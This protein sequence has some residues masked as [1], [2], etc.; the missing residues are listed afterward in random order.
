MKKYA[1]LFV[2][3]FFGAWISTAVAQTFNVTFQ[4]DMSVQIAKTTFDPTKDVIQ[5]RGDF[6]NWGTTDMTPISADSKIYRA[7]IACAAGTAKYKY[8]FKHGTGV[9]AD[10]WESDQA[11]DSHNRE[12]A[13]TAVATVPVVFFNNEVMP[14]GAS[15]D[16]TFKIDMRIPFKQKKLDSV[17]GKVFV[18]GDFNGWNTTANQLTGPAADSTYTALIPINSAQLIHYKFLFNDKSGG[19]PWEDNFA[20]GSGN[21]ETWI[22]DGAQAITKFWNDTDPSVTLKDGAIN[23]TVDM[24]PMSMMNMFNPAIDT[25]KIRGAFN[26][27]GDNDRSKS[28]MFQDPIS[29]NQF[30]NSIAFVGE[31]VGQ[32]ELYKFK[33]QLRTEK[34][35]LVG[36]AQYERPFS[37]GGGNRSVIFAGS[38]SQNTDPAVYYFNDIDPKYIVPAGPGLTAVFKVDMT[39]AMDP[40]KVPIVFDPAQDSVYLVCGQAAWAQVMGWKEDQS[41]SARLTL[42]SGNIYS[43]SLHIP[44]GGFNGF[45]Y[46]YQFAHTADGSLQSEQT[47]FDNW[48]RRVRYIPMSG[49]GQFQQPYFVIVDKYTR[50]AAKPASEYELAPRTL[51]GVEELNTVPTTFT[52]SQNYPNPFNPTTKIKFTLP[53]D[54]LVS[55]KVYNVLGQE[56]A[57]LLNQQM[58]SGSYSYEFDASKLSSGVYFYR[59]EAGNF[60]VTKKMIL[61][62]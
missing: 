17:T 6:N 9:T 51:T 34:G 1:L 14:S 28:T 2:V 60:N 33:M 39:N 35:A 21:R 61:M 54:E 12:F 20:T 40:A 10:V 36:D 32:A 48:N 42:E 4:V 11:T 29:P 57:T 50:D 58:K 8:Y 18:A 7:T 19:T 46:T 43:V 16:V 3:L 56:A 15:A 49:T 44:A 31:K 5:V 27:W 47:G 38:Q 53:S 52:L 45:M 62:K 59:I 13:V 25:L 37:T 41:R 24:T 22:V 26:G 30:F 23:F 55:L